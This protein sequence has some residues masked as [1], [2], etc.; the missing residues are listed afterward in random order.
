MSK[1]TII[2][3]NEERL[4]QAAIEHIHA[5]ENVIAQSNRPTDAF[6]LE[7]IIAL[8]VVNKDRVAGWDDR[9]D[10]RVWQRLSLLLD[11]CF[12]CVYDET[13]LQSEY[14]ALNHQEI[15]N[16]R[17]GIPVLKIV[18]AIDTRAILGRGGRKKHEVEVKIREALAYE[19]FR[20]DIEVGELL[21]AQDRAINGKVIVAERGSGLAHLCEHA[22]VDG[23]PSKGDAR[24]EALEPDDRKE[25]LM[26]SL[27]VEGGS[28]VTKF[29]P[30]AAEPAQ[31]VDLIVKQM[32]A[33]TANMRTRDQYG[34][35]LAA[36]AWGVR[37]L[38]MACTRITELSEDKV[39]LS[40]AT[41][42]ADQRIARRE[43]KEKKRIEELANG[44]RK[45][46]RWRPL[47][48]IAD[49]MTKAM[50]QKLTTPDFSPLELAYIASTAGIDPN[51][52]STNHA[53]ATPELRLA[54]MLRKMSLG[55]PYL[56]GPMELDLL[57]A[58]F[59]D[60]QNAIDIYRDIHDFL[61]RRALECHPQEWWVAE[62]NE[63]DERPAPPVK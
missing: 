53:L 15:I 18:S 59:F 26:T 60:A 16:F 32:A 3:A 40:N 39:E 42:K 56:A 2:L 25:S 30:G 62:L 45:R 37:V 17:S 6:P 38:M 20:R 47:D 21:A 58:L 4:R 29:V 54:Q 27:R 50:H 31:V 10:G 63:L 49:P 11:H 33:S 46:D 12:L 43:E 24:D 5:C 22:W 41:H 13:V 51:L 57:R 28:L 23:V 52:L 34:N 48:P 61:I 55:E 1:P 8:F 19:V 7:A 35:A 36:A 9:V 44:T 14:F